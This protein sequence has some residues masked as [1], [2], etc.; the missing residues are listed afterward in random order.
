VRGLF[1]ALVGAILF[2]LAATTLF[3]PPPPPPPPMGGASL[4]EAR[5]APPPILAVGETAGALV[6]EPDGLETRSAPSTPVIRGFVVGPDG[7]ALAGA[8]AV[9]VEGSAATTDARGWFELAAPELPAVDVLVTAKGHAP[10]AHRV[11]QGATGHRFQ[12][13]VCGLVAVEVVDAAT[14]RPV[15][16]FS[17]QLC[18]ASGLQPRAAPVILSGPHRGG[19]VEARVEVAS[20]A[21]LR[22][23]A[24]DERYAPTALTVVELDVARPDRARLQLFQ[25]RELTVQVVDARALPVPGARVEVLAPPP[26]AAVTLATVAASSWREH[27]VDR[28]S[29][30]SA[31]AT[32]S[33]GSAVVR[34]PAGG[35]IALR[36]SHDVA[37]TFVSNEPDAGALSAR[38]R[39]Q[40]RP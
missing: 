3:A 14:G 35:R 4:S 7:R 5:E 17:V 34:V 9:T 39:V 26:G 10:A 12:L 13:E 36:V 25:W 6:A 21:L 1:A 24:A 32:S 28:A 19:H 31:A 29:L 33:S 27:R 16:T 15:E 2:A 40:L 20:P 30:L 8:R 18:G 11:P 23:V 37:G 22:A 38:I